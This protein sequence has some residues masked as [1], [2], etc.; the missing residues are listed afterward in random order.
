MP[1]LFGLLGLTVDAGWAY[2]RR[3]AAKTA[4][5]AAASGTVSASGSNTPTTQAL[6][7]CPSSLDT[8]KA[9]NVGC[10]FAAKNGFTNGVNNRTV[11]I[12]IGSG[13]S[14]IPVSGANPNKYWVSSTVTEKIPTL[15]SWVL[16]KSSMTVSARSTLGVYSASGGGCMYVL[17]GSASKALNVSGTNFSTGCGVYVFSTAADGAYAS[18]INMS[19]TGGSGMTAHGGF[20]VS[21]SNVTMTGGGSISLSGSLTNS[22]SNITPSGSVKQNQTWPG[23]TNPFS[24][25]TAPSLGSCVPNPNYSGTNTATLSP[26]NYCSGISISASNNVLFQSGIYVLSGGNLTISGSNFS[27]TAT[28]ILIYVPASNTTGQINI[29]GSNANWSGIS[30][31]GADGFVIWVANSQTQTIAGSNNTINGVIYA[32]NATVNYTGSNATQTT[33]VADKV[34][35]TGCNISSPASSTYFSGGGVSAGTYV[36]E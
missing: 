13:A 18:G 31:Q 30:G 23:T 22:G 5:T 28:N 17:D 36:L 16:G 10:D 32:P 1:V 11:A 26:G 29:G 14:G 4:A 21:G 35:V 3:E 8:T 27:T 7:N 19:F 9:W 12:Q 24:G 15:F 20:S 33:L 2:W 25:M 34:V 6:T